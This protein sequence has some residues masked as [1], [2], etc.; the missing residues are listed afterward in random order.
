LISPDVSIL[1]Y[2]IN[3]K[4]GAVIYNIFH[5]QGFAFLAILIGYNI[6][7]IEMILVGSI[8][9]GHSSMDRVLGYGLKY[10]DDFRNTHLGWIG[11]K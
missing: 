10:K 2:L 1:A 6:K 5:H 4:W 9:L 8:L 7:S 3:K 11:K